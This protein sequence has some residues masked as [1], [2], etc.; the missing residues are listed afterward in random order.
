MY[1]ILSPMGV[2]VL[3]LIYLSLTIFSLVKMFGRE[4][5]LMLFLWLFVIVA[6]PFVGSLLYLLYFYVNRLKPVVN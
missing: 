5:K 3:L 6:F 1:G 4:K 2:I